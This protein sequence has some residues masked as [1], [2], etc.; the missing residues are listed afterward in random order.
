MAECG[1]TAR[2]D[3]VLYVNVIEVPGG[4]KWNDFYGYNFN[5]GVLLLSLTTLRQ[6]KF[7]DKIV[8]HW[9][10][11]LGFNDQVV[12]N[13]ACNGTHGI[14]NETMNMLMTAGFSKSRNPTRIWSRIC[15]IQVLPNGWLCTSP[16]RL[17]TYKYEYDISTIDSASRMLPLCFLCIKTPFW[18]VDM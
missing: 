18:Y 3:N 1:I 6:N 4:L 5:A 11:D 2:N 10:I 9:G 13:M 17:T 14:L 15:I 7:E 8:Q 16:A 12:L